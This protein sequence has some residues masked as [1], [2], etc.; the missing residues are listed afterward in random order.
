MVRLLTLAA[1][2]V[3]AGALAGCQAFWDLPGQMR[4]PY[5]GTASPPAP[6]QDGALQNQDTEENLP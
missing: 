4:A 1:A 6:L 5:G 2:L 3:S